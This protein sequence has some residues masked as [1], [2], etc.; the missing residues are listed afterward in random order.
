M[1][2]LTEACC[3]FTVDA[4]SCNFTLGPCCAICLNNNDVALGFYIRLRFARFFEGVPWSF[5]FSLSC[6][7]ACVWNIIALPACHCWDN[8]GIAELNSVHDGLV[9]WL[10]VCVLRLYFWGLMW[11]RVS[12]SKPC[13]VLRL[14]R[15]CSDPAR[16][17][18]AESDCCDLI[19][20]CCGFTGYG[21]WLLAFSFRIPP[22]THPSRVLR[23]AVSRVALPYR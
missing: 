8:G 20:I 4:L 18:S 12:C 5:L 23:C 17:L 22:L 1:L 2:Y 16:L 9:W 3:I 13:C 15:N 14:L 6:C 7:V 19:F 21:Y 11:R 10:L